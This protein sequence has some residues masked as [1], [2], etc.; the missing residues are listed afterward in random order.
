MFIQYN[1]NHL[2]K[3]VGDC[4]VRAIAKALNIDWTTAY[5]KLCIKG[6]E[7]GDMPSADHV[8]GAVLHQNGFKRESLPNLC[9]DCYTADDFCRD[10]PKGVFVLGFGGHTAT[11]VD[12]DIYDVW[13]SSNEI[14]Q[15]VW[16]K[17]NG[18]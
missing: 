12:G 1:P 3:R 16:R 5:V 9:P 7:L 15:F 2:G 4:A 14:P 11:V 6:I 10:N 8:W 18:L 17:D 13:D